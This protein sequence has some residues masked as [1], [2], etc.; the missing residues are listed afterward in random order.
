MK[1]K[2]FTTGTYK[3]IFGDGGA[4][5]T[6]GY[7]CKILKSDNT[8]VS[9]DG[10]ITVGH[11][12]GT[13][14]G[15]VGGSGG[16]GNKN[17]AGSATHGLTFWNG[18][19]YVADG[20]NGQNGGSYSGGGTGGSSEPGGTNGGLE[21]GD[22]RMINITGQSVFYGGGGEGGGYG[23]TT[24]GGGGGGGTG[25]WGSSGGSGTPNT[26]EGGGGAYSAST[27]SRGKGGSGIIMKRYR[28]I[29]ST[30]IGS[31]I[32][33]KRAT[34]TY[35]IGNYNSDFKIISSDSGTD[36]ERFIVNSAG[37]VGIGTNVPLYKLQVE[38]TISTST[39]ITTGNVGIGATNPANILQ[40]GSDGRLKIANNTVDYTT[41]GG[42][43]ITT[44]A[45][46]SRIDLY[47]ITY[48][49]TY[50]RGNRYFYAQDFHV[51]TC[52]DIETFR[53]TPGGI[54]NTYG[55]SSG[56]LSINAQTSTG[57]LVV[58]TTRRLLGYVTLNLGA[59]NSSFPVEVG[60]GNVNSGSRTLG[61]FNYNTPEFYGAST[62]LIDVCSR[63]NSS[64]WCTSWIVSSS[65][66]R[67]KEDGQ[68]INDDSALNMILA[69]EPKTYRYI[70]KIEKGDKK[71]HGFI[72]QQIREVLPDDVSL[73]PN[74]IPT[75][76]LLA[77]YDN[78]IITLPTQP[79]KVIIKINDKLDVM[80]KIIK[81]LMLK[82]LK[83]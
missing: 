7:D 36:T 42:D 83:L 39:L 82:L 69:I 57:S 38:G 28:N 61:Y 65:D 29:L 50:N 2:T 72:A 54:S 24:G 32:E 55:M 78:E 35:K 37:R 74:F 21:G 71:V 80:I 12:G 15:D 81:I 52:N 31:E 76:M 4:T 8:N 40:V 68:D 77:D 34:S 16:G 66:I 19:S 26:G 47:G 33:L 9:Y 14:G 10:L 46:S 53:V 23:I 17:G 20:F 43:D 62:T 73:Q 3:I 60:Y 70:N 59:N 64:V 48:A 25:N 58:N 79:T 75:I 6:V 67:I 22:R 44:T 30:T 13:G 5:G 51:F 11:G 1:E 49:N 27:V 63:F 41:I 18:T 56:S 45:T